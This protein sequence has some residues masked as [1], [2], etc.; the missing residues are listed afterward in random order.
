MRRPAW[1]PEA[2]WQR[3]DVELRRQP[4]H[5]EAA[6]DDLSAL[7]AEWDEAARARLLERYLEYAERGIPLPAAFISSLCDLLHGDG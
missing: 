1:V 5:A 2:A 6:L 4:R 3:L 7:V